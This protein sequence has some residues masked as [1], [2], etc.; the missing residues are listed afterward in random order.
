MV[1]FIHGNP[2][3]MPVESITYPSTADRSFDPERIYKHGDKKVRFN[4][5]S[6]R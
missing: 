6:L 5:I 4:E 1:K 3:G 2:L